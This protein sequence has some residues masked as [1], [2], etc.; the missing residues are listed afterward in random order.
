MNLLIY[1]TQAELFEDLIEYIVAIA[2]K[3]H[4]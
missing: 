4:N 3:A 2:D 1:K